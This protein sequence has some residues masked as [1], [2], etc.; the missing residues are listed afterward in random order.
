MEA[1][2]LSGMDRAG[3][4]TSMALPCLRRESRTRSP[5]LRRAS[6]ALKSAAL[7]S[8]LPSRERRKSSVSTSTPG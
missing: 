6:R 1:V 8:G 7:S 5:S 2:S 3:R 4:E